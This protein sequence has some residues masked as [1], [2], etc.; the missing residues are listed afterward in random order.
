MFQENADKI[1][2]YDAFVQT[3]RRTTMG[4]QKT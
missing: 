3:S 1:F 2:Q 4:N